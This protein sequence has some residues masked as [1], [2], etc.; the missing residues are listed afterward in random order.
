VPCKER[1]SARRRRARKGSRARDSGARRGASIPAKGVLLSA[2]PL[3]PPGA[4][5]PFWEKEKGT[6]G[7]PRAV[8]QQGRRSVGSFWKAKADMKFV[9]AAVVLI[10]SSAHAQ[11]SDQVTLDPKD[12]PKPVAEKIDCEGP[13]TFVMRRPF[14]GGVVF[15]APCPG[16][17]A[18]S[19]QALVYADNAQGANARRLMFPRPGKKSEV[20]PADSLSNIRWFPQTR[21]LTELFVDPESDLCRT[22]GRWRLNAKTQPHLMFWRQTR[23]CAGKTGWRVLV[24]R[25]KR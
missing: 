20:N 12:V 22:E 10:V 3:A 11:T 16:N 23:D 18:N 14:A 8:K 2:A 4:P 19:I 7:A 25:R 13:K 17:H 15:A 9:L 24:D 1:W 21:E 5:F 6:K